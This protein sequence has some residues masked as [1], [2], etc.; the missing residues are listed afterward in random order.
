MLTRRVGAQDAADLVQESFANFAG[1]DPA[2]PF[3]ER[4]AGFLQRIAVNLVR[5]PDRV[6]KR[7]QEAQNLSMDESC[8]SGPDPLAMLE[9]VARLSPRTRTVFLARRVEGL[10]YAEI[11]E[12]TGLSAK[13]IEKHMSKAIAALDRMLDRR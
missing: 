3:I 9:A 12:R 2:R 11:S 4:P 7:D 6:R 13:R 5:H 8:H 1:R 10:S